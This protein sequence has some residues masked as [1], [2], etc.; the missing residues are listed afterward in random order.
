[1]KT[2]Q[3]RYCPDISFLVLVLVAIA[4]TCV[5]TFVIRRAQLAARESSCTGHIY[6]ITQ[7]VVD[8]RREHGHFPGAV[9][10]ESAHSWRVLILPQLGYNDL[11]RQYDFD[12]PWNSRNNQTVM[13]QM[14]SIYTC[15][16]CPRESF[17]SYF[18]VPENGK[19]VLVLESNHQSIYWTEPKDVDGLRV[20]G[21][22]C[23]PNGRGVGLSDGRIVRKGGLQG[24]R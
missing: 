11:Y 23:D 19:S 22:A 12:Q 5:L 8:Y 24:N 16:N 4:A 21:A 1:M 6:K 9:E 14:P 3:R 2:S 20:P 10:A 15:P 7:A 13:K 18:L 17:T